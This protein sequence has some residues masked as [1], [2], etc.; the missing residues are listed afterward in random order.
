MSEK[1]EMPTTDQCETNAKVYEDQTQVG[2]AIWYPQMG[3]YVGRAVALMDKGWY[4]RAKGGTVGGCFDILVWH[5]GE[6][7]FG[8]DRPVELHHCD[9][10]QF[11]EFGETIRELNERRKEPKP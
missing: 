9:P 3:G 10:E 5:D 1:I 8:G 11:I 4:E 7:P 6:F 2:Y